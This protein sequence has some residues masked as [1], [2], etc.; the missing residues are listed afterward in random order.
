MKAELLEND[1]DL[2]ALENYYAH[3]VGKAVKEI[4]AI[5][6]IPDHLEGILR[7]KGH[8]MKAVDLTA[9]ISQ[10]PGFEQT[11][12]QTVTGALIRYVN[13]GKRFI[14]TAPNTYYILEEGK[15]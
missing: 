3:L 11:A 4:S 6:S 14:R 12:Q 13:K 2:Q 15:E 5:K 7:N 9:A 10:I 8:P 1:R